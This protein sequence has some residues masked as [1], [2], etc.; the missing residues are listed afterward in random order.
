MENGLEMHGVV[1]GDQCHAHTVTLLR[2]AY[3]YARLSPPSPPGPQGA[4][5]GPESGVEGDLGRRRETRDRII[6][7]TAIPF[8]ILSTHPAVPA[9]E[10]CQ[11]PT[12]VTHCACS[13]SEADAVSQNR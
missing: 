8:P 7:P 4:R 2:T 11:I 10:A 12:G 1:E 5:G 3:R 9:P 13:L 6:R